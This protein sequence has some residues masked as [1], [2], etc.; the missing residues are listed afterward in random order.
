MHGRWGRSGYDRRDRPDDWNSLIRVIT[1]NVNQATMDAEAERA[2]REHP[3]SL[4]KRDLMFA[5][6]STSLE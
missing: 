1:D 5:A 6:M 3:D 4:D 2:T